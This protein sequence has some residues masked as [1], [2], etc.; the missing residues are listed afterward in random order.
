[1]AQHKTVPGSSLA[2]GLQVS[3]VVDVS[4]SHIEGMQAVDCACIPS[5]W[6]QLTSTTS[7]HPNHNTSSRLCMGLA[8]SAPYRTYEWK[9]ISSI[10]QTSSHARQVSV[11]LITPT[12]LQ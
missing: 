11:G 5:M 1:M 4:H 7:P 3:N 12:L 8:K 2:G 6:L 9:G 10:Q